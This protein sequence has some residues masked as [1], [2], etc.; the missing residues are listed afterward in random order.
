MDLR[1]VGV[2]HLLQ[3]QQNQSNR[4]VTKAAKV[5]FIYFCGLRAFVFQSLERSKFPESWSHDGKW[6]YYSSDVTGR[7]EIW[8]IPPGG[9]A[10]QQITRNGAYAGLESTDGKNLYYTVFDQKSSSY[11]L[12][13]KPLD[14]GP[15]RKILD[16]VSMQLISR[17]SRTGSIIS[18]NER[19]GS[20]FP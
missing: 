18:R 14:G 4:Q 13:A 12:M 16:Q 5:L 9:G 15:E 6:I 10:A 8:R 11:S 3:L 20:C 2:I 7:Y 19:K 1:T 17:Y